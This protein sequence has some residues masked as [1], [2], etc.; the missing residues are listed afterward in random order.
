MASNRER[1]WDNERFAVVGHSSRKPFPK[2]SYGELKRRSKKVF[3]VDP[4]VD[5]ILGDR[6]Y[7]D[8]ASLPQTV[9]AVV[10]EVPRDETARWVE[11]A[12]D[13]GIKHVW[14]HMLRE[15]PEALEVAK[16]RGLNLRTGSCAMMYLS[17]GLSYH[18]VH[19]S[20]DKALGRY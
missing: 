1:F 5:T 17:Q 4:S 11:R 9:D 14:I 19:R 7:F 20:L 15:T 10:I 18:A 2:L 16:S 12:A 8:L 6:T 13:A 3:A